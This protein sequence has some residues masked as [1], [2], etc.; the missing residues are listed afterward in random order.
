MTSYKPSDIEEGR[1]SIDVYT[2]EM[3]SS[4]IEHLSATV[5]MWGERDEDGVLVTPWLITA[6]GLARVFSEND[7][8]G[9]RLHVAQPR[10]RGGLRTHTV[11]H[12]VD[13]QT[14]PDEMRTKVKIHIPISQMLSITFTNNPMSAGMF[15][16]YS[17]LANPSLTTQRISTL[18]SQPETLEVATERRLDGI[19]TPFARRNRLI[20]LG[21]LPVLPESPQS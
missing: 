13:I 11:Q 8:L 20:F 7:N 12:I 18:L 6:N 15:M 10:E 21:K 14:N 5:G 4:N 19:F 2:P 9:A 16:G 17:V 1:H 3:H